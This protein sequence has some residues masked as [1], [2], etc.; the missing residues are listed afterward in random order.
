MPIQTDPVRILQ[1]TPDHQREWDSYVDQSRNGVFLFNRNYMDYHA[2]RFK[3]HSL[4]FYR[5][6]KLAGLFPANIK[7]DAL[8][9]HGGLTFG[10]VIVGCS[11]KTLAMLQIFDALLSYC[12]RNGFKTVFYKAVPYIYHSVPTNEDLYALFRYNARLVARNASS[13][14]SLHSSH[15]FSDGRKYSINKALKNGLV[16]KQTDDLD[17]FMQLLKETLNER[18]NVNPVH[19]TEEIKLLAGRFPCNIKLFASYLGERMLSGLLVYESK[20]VAHIQYAANCK[21]GMDLGAQDLIEDYLINN[22]Y[23]DKPYYDFG[24][25]TENFGQV[26]NEGLIARKETFGANSVMYDQYEI[27][28]T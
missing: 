25:S 4:M 19:T 17:S 12:R 18:H 3:D 28:V 20:N 9:S 24:I 1:Y 6:N 26:L 2:D 5:K 13:C 16:V 27:S 22:Y 23:K 21:Q 8:Q 11:T 10:G 15:P 14:I 7:D